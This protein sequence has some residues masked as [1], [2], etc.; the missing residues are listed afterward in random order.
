M[1][2]IQ[3]TAYGG[4]EVLSVAELPDPDP[5]AG[6][7]AIDVTHAA[8]GLIDV[9]LRR[10]ALKDAPGMVQPPFTPGLEVAGTVRSL[11]SGV[12]GFHIGEHVVS[13]SAGGGTGGYASVYIAPVRGVVSIESS[14]IDP[15]LAVAAIPNA[16]MAHI[17]LTKVAHMEKCESLL[18]HGALGGLS[19][20]FP[21]IARQLG[22]SRIVGTVRAGKL[23]AAAD[24]KLPYDLIVDSDEMAEQLGNE[25]FDVVIDPVG[26]AVRSQSLALMQPGSRL[27]AAGNASD[28]WSHQIR[29]NDL[30]LGCVTI[31]G[32]NAG[33]YIPSHPQALRPAL[34][35]ALEAVAGGLVATE[36]D[37]LPFSRAVEAHQ[38]MDARKVNGR[39]VLTP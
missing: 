2:A 18:V 20:A 19:A 28:D 21:G 14:G 36:I 32:F 22:A 27:I 1:K 17:A 4:P 8:V 15:A 30:W 13:M 12:T 34:A 5:G 37:I 10:G 29:S 33:A 39:I 25:K 24:T 7:I 3:V 38:R 23:G 31:T 9:L 26:G 35:A 6:E 16:A 11:G